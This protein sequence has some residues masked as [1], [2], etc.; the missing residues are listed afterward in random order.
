[1]GIGILGG[2]GQ[3]K[4]C[5]VLCEERALCGFR[6]LLYPVVYAAYLRTH[7]PIRQEYAGELASKCEG[8]R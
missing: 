2:T 7:F 5:K 4:R 1:M 8:G 3:A 6:K